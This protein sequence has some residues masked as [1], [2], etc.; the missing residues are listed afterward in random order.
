MVLYYIGS[1]TSVDFIASFVRFLILATARQLM[2]R[3]CRYNADAGPGKADLG[4]IRD[5]IVWNRIQFL[6]YKGSWF[7]T[8][9]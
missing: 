3:K 6:Q 9:Y 2:Y 7:L 4:G 5:M 1:T 8:R